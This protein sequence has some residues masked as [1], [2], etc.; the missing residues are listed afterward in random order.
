MGA[1]FRNPDQ[2]FT[3]MTDEK[4]LSDFYYRLMVPGQLFTGWLMGKIMGDFWPPILQL[5][6]T[7]LVFM[8]NLLPNKVNV[9]VAAIMPWN[10]RVLADDG[11]TRVPLS[12]RAAEY[13]W[14]PKP[15]NIAWEYPDK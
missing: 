10:P 8:L 6:L 5:L 3:D 11:F 12:A 1:G 7:Y 13:L 2:I 9:L 14:M 15:F 4:A